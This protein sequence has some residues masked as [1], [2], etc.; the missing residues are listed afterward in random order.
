M[1][2]MI[3]VVINLALIFVMLVIF[4]IILMETYP[5]AFTYD[6]MFMI[7]FYPSSLQISEIFLLTRPLI[8]R[9]I[10][11]SISLYPSTFSLAFYF[12]HFS[13][14]LF[15]G[16]ILFAHLF[17]SYFGSG[18]EDREASLLFGVVEDI[19]GID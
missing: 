17:M 14:R 4:F 10:D 11:F 12:T 6:I 3:E 7:Y 15:F 9:S 19:V 1:V 8:E 5:L 18:F 2:R 13:F 16:N